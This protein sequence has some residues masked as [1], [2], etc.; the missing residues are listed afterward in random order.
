MALSCRDLILAGLA[1]FFAWGYA[2]HWVP[3][4]RWTGYA[5]TAGIVLTILGF[6]FFLITTSRG[7][8]YGL[9]NRISGPR[10]PAFLET[11]A[12]KAELAALRK[13]QIYTKQPLYA[14]SYFIS[15]ALDELLIL[16]NRDFVSSWYQNISSN[17][18][19]SNEV[20]KVIRLALGSIRDRLLTTNLVDIV[21]MRFVPILTEHF[22][23]FYDAERTVRGKNL[24]RNVTESDELDL[25]IAGKYRDGKLH[26]AA[27]L[28]FADTKLVQ[29]D[30]LRNL[31]KKI[32]P[33]VLLEKI[34][35]SHAVSVLVE[36]LVSCAVLFPAMQMLSDPDT[37]NQLMEAYVCLFD[38]HI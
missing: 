15:D 6:I 26:P 4:L 37:W 24:N 16:I 9:R 29:Q 18:I 34:I 17:R 7:S 28:A 21:T 5:F 33:Q 38:P 32:L 3:T 30:Y 31:S 2:V 10:G 36:E 27:S 19:F 8:D 12:W 23:D 13:Q 25:A 20:D 22:K 14:E 11:R 35:G 1:I